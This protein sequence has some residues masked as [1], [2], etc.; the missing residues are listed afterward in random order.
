VYLK[1]EK[2]GGGG[3]PKKNKGPFEEKITNKGRRSAALRVSIDANAYETRSAHRI[4][5]LSSKG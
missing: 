2:R 3:K 5:T 4:E 1:R